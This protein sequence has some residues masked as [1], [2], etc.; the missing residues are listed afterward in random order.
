MDKRGGC[1]TSR[2][3]SPLGILE[4]KRKRGGREGGRIRMNEYQN[5]TVP[6]KAV[7]PVTYDLPL[8]STS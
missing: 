2:T 7:L 1:G 5:S 3:F 6:F 4:A 8:S